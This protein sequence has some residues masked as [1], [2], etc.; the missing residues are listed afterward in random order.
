M[1]AR[2]LSLLTALV[3]ALVAASP[4]FAKP[5]KTVTISGHAYA[6]DNQTTDL[7]GATIRVRELPKLSAVTDANGD[8]RLKVPAE[9]TVTPYIEPPDGYNQ[10]DL[11]TFQT[12]G[13]DLE[14]VNFQ[15]P[16]DASYNA[17]A[18]LLGVSFGPD[19]RPVDCVIVSTASARNVRDVSFDTFVERTPHGVAGATATEF[20]EIPGP[21]YFNDSVIPDVSRTE[22]SGDGG[23]IWTHVPT[24][25][26]RVATSSPTT[27]FAGF[28]ATCEPGRIVNANPPW[29]AY[30]LSP[31]EEPLASGVAVATVGEANISRPTTDNRRSLYIGVKSP[32]TVSVEAVLSTK[33]GREL[34]TVKSKK[35]KVL[36]FPIR[37]GL[38]GRLVARITLTDKSGGVAKYK[39]TKRVN[40]VK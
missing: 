30:E 24:D 34:R 31:G 1:R 19:G 15:T 13:E 33:A 3:V 18:A 21:V 9:A 36:R 29:G 26:Y 16:A 14:N 37:P 23:M 35:A 28:L 27:R 6:F 7:V 25:T 17:L 10:I 8:Y 32:E 2:H 12:R 39:R 11:Q 20:P 22:T 40:A 4:A 5:A 38:S